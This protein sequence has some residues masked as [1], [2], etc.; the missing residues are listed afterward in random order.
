[1]MTDEWLQK[2]TDKWLPLLEE[3]MIEA[4]PKAFAVIAES[5]FDRVVFEILMYRY[6]EY[7][8]YSGISKTERTQVSEA[9]AAATAI[10][11]T[12]LG[13]VFARYGMTEESAPKLRLLGGS[14]DSN[15][16]LLAKSLRDYYSTNAGN[17][18]G[19]QV[20]ELFPATAA[21]MERSIEQAFKKIFTRA[22]VYQ[23]VETD[24]ERAKR[25]AREEREARLL[26]EK[27]TR[28]AAS[29]PIA[30]VSWVDV[31]LYIHDTP[32]LLEVIRGSEDKK[33]VTEAIDKVYHNEI[34]DDIDLIH[35]C[36]PGKCTYTILEFLAK[37]TK[38]SVYSYILE[39]K[40]VRVIIPVLQGDYFGRD[41]LELLDSF[42][43][44]KYHRRC[45]FE[46][47][48]GDS[49]G[50][51]EILKQ[52]D[53]PDPWE[54]FKNIDQYYYDRLGQVDDSDEFSYHSSQDD[55]MDQYTTCGYTLRGWRWKL[56]KEANLLIEGVD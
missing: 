54:A 14:R 45:N 40:L 32:R 23:P 12:A 20:E 15:T 16:S 39:E 55:D 28:E 13:I 4:I 53:N 24:F 50:Y 30:E 7:Y 37:E 43:A 3:A 27:L 25:K 22:E 49:I 19:T 52:I 29:K 26:E 2:L 17:V 18:S 56:L 48:C 41:V 42:H 51:W 38:R 35:G 6:A 5:G 36:L 31:R 10:I 1:M 21:A 8:V 34:A 9:E 47:G 46:E 11:Q 33:I 44:R